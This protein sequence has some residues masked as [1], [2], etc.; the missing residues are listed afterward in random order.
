MKN[1]AIITGASSGIGRDIARVVDKK[2]LFLDEIW[3]VGRNEDKLKALASFFVHKTEIV[4]QDL[5]KPSALNKLRIMIE[6]NDINI[7]LL[8]NSAGIGLWDKFD[9]H[10]YVKLREMLRLNIEALTS[11]TYNCLPKMDD[12]SR[13]INLASSAAYL[14]QPYFVVYAATKSYV[15]SFSRGLRYEL[16]HRGIKVSA[17]CPGP[18]DTGFF[19]AMGKG[20]GVPK[21]SSLMVALESYNQ[22]FR[23]KSVIT[24]GVVFKLF[25]LVAKLVPHELLLKG[26]MLI[27]DAKDFCEKGSLRAKCIQICKKIFR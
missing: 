19:D 7:R 11:L 6:E 23:G 16:K 24:P 10:D 20:K 18:V 1:I 21:Y 9:N 27:L 14:P 25:R 4:V 3:L 13:I 22:N 15:L 8:V 2:E 17:V 5:T 12:E 26:Y